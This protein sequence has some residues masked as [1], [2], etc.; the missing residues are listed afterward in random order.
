MVGVWVSA[1]DG[2]WVGFLYSLVRSVGILSRVLMLSVTLVSSPVTCLSLW[3]R[4][5][6]LG[7]VMRGAWAASV[8]G[9]AVSDGSCCGT[10]AGS[11]VCLHLQRCYRLRRGYVNI[12]CLTSQQRSLL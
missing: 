4:S 6:H 2:L 9:V 7:C 5:V 8:G 12:I 1:V 10:W 11:S 3:C